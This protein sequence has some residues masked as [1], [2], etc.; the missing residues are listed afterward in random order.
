MEQA[1][2]IWD[3]EDDPEGNIQHIAEHDITRDEVEEVLNEGY[4][5][6]TFSRSSER[7][8]TFGWTTTGKYIAVIYEEVEQ[9]P[10]ILRPVT[11]FETNP[12]S[13]KKGRKRH[14]H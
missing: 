13:G 4:E 6:S 12:P 8:I 3:L 5:D 1:Q 7:P 2:I 11:A 9:D 14:G 10:L